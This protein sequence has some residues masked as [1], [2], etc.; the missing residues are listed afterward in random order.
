MQAMLIR[1]AIIGA[2]MGG[3]LLKIYMLSNEVDKYALRVT[4][5][6]TQVA[7]KN[8]TITTIGAN[9]KELSDK[10]DEMGVAYA[11]YKSAASSAS[12]ELARW[13]A[14]PPTI[15]YKV[16]NELVPGMAPLKDANCSEGLELNK[17]ISELRYADL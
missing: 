10:L 11:K 6:E 1:L 8:N 13:K 2:V 15:K 4:N 17:A 3:M 14:K 9:N 12:A 5:Y 16:V 7:A